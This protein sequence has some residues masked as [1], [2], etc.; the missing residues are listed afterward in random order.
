MTDSENA[1]A[2]AL[3]FALVSLGALLKLNDIAGCLIGAGSAL[4][5]AISLRRAIVKAAQDNEENHQRMEIQFQQLRSKIIETSEVNITAM[6]SVNAAAQLVQDNMQVI[7][8]MLADLAHLTQFAELTEEFQSTVANLDEN[9][10]A[11]NLTL[12]REFEKLHA[13]EET[14]KENLQN[15]VELLQILNNPI[16]ATENFSALN[17]TLEREFERLRAIEETNARNLQNILELLQVLQNP[18]YTQD[19]EKINL[20]INKLTEQ[21]KTMQA[22][23]QPALNRQ[24]L[25]MLKK[26]AAKIK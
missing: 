19:I 17:L 2:G 8:V 22:E 15:I 5:A 9:S 26:I 12:E 14:N 6:N 25:S 23:I 20:S 13:I 3:F 1:Y 7:R 16:Y 4:L 11:L 24:D 21:F 18:I 10:A